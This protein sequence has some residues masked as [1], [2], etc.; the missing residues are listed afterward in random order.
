MHTHSVDPSYVVRSLFARSPNIDRW[1]YDTGGE[2]DYNQSENLCALLNKA[3]AS[4]FDLSVENGDRTVINC[5]RY[6]N[7]FSMIVV[8]EGGAIL[9][10]FLL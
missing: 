3:H 10:V 5:I 1:R 2:K 9:N 6:S 7:Y 4:I 8:L